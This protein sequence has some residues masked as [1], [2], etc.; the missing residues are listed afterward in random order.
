MNFLKE[1][2]LRLPENLF[3]VGTVNMDDTT[4]QFSRKVID[5]AFTIEMNG[6]KLEK[7]FDTKDTL[8]YQDTPMPLDDIKPLFVKAQ[9]VLDVYPNDAKTIKEIVPGLLERINGEG[10][11]KDTPFRVSYRVQNELVLYYAAIRP[12][13]D[14]TEE[15]II[16]YLYEA[17]MA[18]LLEKILPRVEGDEKAMKCNEKG[19]SVII[20]NIEN[21]LNELKPAQGEPSPT[22][23]TL[24][25]KLNEMNERVKNSYFTSFFS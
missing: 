16:P 10:I 13:G 5:R 22:Y 21:Y 3:V 2:G 18:V 1:K 11:F 8:A 19:D 6:D 9:E 14:F 7:M 15:Q 4:H 25:A 12:Q 17:F 20:K 24:M 23:I